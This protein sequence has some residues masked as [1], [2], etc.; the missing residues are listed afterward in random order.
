MKHQTLLRRLD[1]CVQPFADLWNQ[2]AVGGGQQ[3]DLLTCFARQN[4]T[5]RPARHVRHVVSSSGQ[6]ACSGLTVCG[7]LDHPGV[8]AAGDDRERGTRV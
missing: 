5:L 8:H 6:Q 7:G 4:K 2:G 1:I 3:A